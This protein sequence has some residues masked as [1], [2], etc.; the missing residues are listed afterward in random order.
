LEILKNNKVIPEFLR[1]LVVGGISFIVDFNTLLI[2]KEFVL[3]DLH[4]SLYI[5]TAMGFL[6]GLAVNYLL[7]LHYVFNSAKGTAIGR[8]MNEILLFG[9]IGI[10]GLI[11]SEFGM[12]MG[13]EKFEFNYLLVK[14][15]VTAIVLLWNYLARKIL[16]FNK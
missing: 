3:K 13:S 11:I 2:F 7:S 15:A 14:V 6:V 4:Y 16:I 1:Y 8:S 5:S 9:A 10:I 12:F